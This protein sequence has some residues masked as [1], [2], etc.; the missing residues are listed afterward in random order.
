M[1]K[2]NK[3]SVLAVLGFILVVLFSACEDE[4]TTPT[5]S[6]QPTYVETQV[7]HDRTPSNG[8]EIEAQFTLRDEVASGKIILFCFFRP[9]ADF[10]RIGQ[11]DDEIE[12]LKDANDSL[13]GVIFDRWAAGTLSE[14]DSLALVQ[15]KVDNFDG[16]SQREIERDVLDTWLDDRFKVA[17]RLNDDVNKKYPLA[18]QLN[19]SSINS[20]TGTET[21]EFLADSTIIWGQ[22]IHLAEGAV[23]GWYGKRIE[24]NLDEFWIA[25]LD[26]VHPQKPARDDFLTSPS[27]PD[28]YTAYELQPVR[29]W[30]ELLTPGTTHT[31]KITLGSS[32]V[33]TQVSASLYLVYKSAT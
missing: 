20:S 1:K 24:I 29:N 15:M 4:I 19:S 31:L 28:R 32:G 25:D 5:E 21:L 18:I 3:Y 17:I 23:E 22:G 30:L 7:L 26:W 14:A 16:I 27:Y 13:S 10:L 8:V 33:E 11:L 9:D 2:L 12:G 6:V